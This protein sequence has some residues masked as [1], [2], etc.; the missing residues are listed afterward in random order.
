MLSS[1]VLW[2][3]GISVVTFLVIRLFTRISQ[4]AGLAVEP[5]ARRQHSGTIPLI[6]G[7]SIFL[8]YMIA[9]TSLNLVSPLFIACAAILMITGLIDDRFEISSLLRFSIQALVAILMVYG[10]GPVLTSL[11]LGVFPDSVSKEPLGI[12]FTIIATI[13]LMN[14]FNMID[15][16]DGLAAVC[17]MSCVSLL[18][19][20]LGLGGVWPAPSFILQSAI[21]I[22]CLLGFLFVNLQ[23]LTW[24]KVFLGDAGS[25][26]LGFILAWW[27]IDFSQQPTTQAHI[28]PAMA[29][30]IL[31]IP[32]T[33]TL[34]I[35]IRRVRAG[36]S[37]FAG[38]R[39]HLHHILQR[40]GL[41]P[42]QVLFAFVGLAYL[43]FGLGWGLYSFTTPLISA[44]AFFTLPFFIFPIL[45]TI[46][47]RYG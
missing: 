44:L 43:L 22:G 38:D 2:L 25:T 30:W 28:P 19:I 40:A 18:W 11:G 35:I 36:K 3:S 13:G 4:K 42:R 16:M 31:A 8:V 41:S 15:G 9:T 21:F 45:K 7:F 32:V 1:F 34:A 37:P 33:D 6:G 39:K 20:M 5:D 23:I 12:I 26:L 27:V 29:L 17:A 46:L 24:R 14:A 10:D 47:A